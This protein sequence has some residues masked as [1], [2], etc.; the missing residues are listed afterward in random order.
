MLK[1]SA[2]IETVRGAVMRNLLRWIFSAPGV[3]LDAERPIFDL[4]Y[5]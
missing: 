2:C 1:P 5:R 3:L 4:I